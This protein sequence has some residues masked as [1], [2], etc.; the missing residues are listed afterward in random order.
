MIQFKE[1]KNREDFIALKKGDIVACEFHRDV[2]D[3]PK[4]YRFNVF[5]IEENKESHSEIILQKKN[6]IYFNWKLF[7]GEEEGGS[8]LKSI[9]LLTTE[10]LSSDVNY[11][12]YSYSDMKKC[13][14]KGIDRGC[15]IASVIWGTP[16]DKFDT[17]DEFINKTYIK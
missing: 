4:K 12:K 3:F 11:K 2:N 5:K 8:N 14:S 1:L 16:I 13:F 15:Y 6:N 17:F 10:D 9:I 7:L